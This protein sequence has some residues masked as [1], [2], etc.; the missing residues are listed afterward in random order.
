[1]YDPTTSNSENRVQVQP[2]KAPGSNDGMACG[3]INTS[4]QY[5]GTLPS[6][7]KVI[8]FIKTC[9]IANLEFK[10]LFTNTFRQIMNFEE[11]NV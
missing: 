4:T 9:R 6:S 10:I 8:T 3:S 1:M 2:D 7:L 5:S 11:F